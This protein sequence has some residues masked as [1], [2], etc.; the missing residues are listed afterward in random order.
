VKIVSDISSKKI[1]A[2]T[3]ETTTPDILSENNL[4]RAYIGKT[5]STIKPE[6]ITA[7][8]TDFKR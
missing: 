3:N 4:V 8:T 5:M 2:H 7:S 1:K 6:A